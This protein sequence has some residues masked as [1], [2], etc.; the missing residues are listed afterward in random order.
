MGFGCPFTASSERQ[1]DIC[2]IGLMSVLGSLI[3][4]PELSVQGEVGNYNGVSRKEQ[5]E[6]GPS[7][8]VNE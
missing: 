8:K 5:T 6:T 1:I 7:R 3:A 4:M 2:S